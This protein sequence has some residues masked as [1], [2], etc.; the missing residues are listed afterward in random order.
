DWSIA[1]IADDAGLA[2]A[3][4]YTN[5]SW[6]YRSILGGLYSGGFPL[7]TRSLA[8]TPVSVSVAG[9][10]SSYVRFRIAA[11]VV[12][13]VVA[14]SSGSAVPSTVDLTLIRTQ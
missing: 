6:N 3:S 11:N 13:N 7:L 5:P 12:A 4:N 1:Q 9:G 10:G 8:S 14:K 2:P